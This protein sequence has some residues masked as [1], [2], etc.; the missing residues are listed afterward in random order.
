MKEL[1]WNEGLGGSWLV[2]WGDCLMVFEMVFWKML[3]G[4]KKKI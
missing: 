1:I 4:K 2:V 3:L